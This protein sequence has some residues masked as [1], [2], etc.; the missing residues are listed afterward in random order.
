M[1]MALSEEWAKSTYSAGTDGC[2][3]VRLIGETIE[4]RDSKNR[5]GGSL[6]FTKNEWEAFQSGAIDGEFDL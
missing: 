2:V 6:K 4:V 5:D 3:E 1:A